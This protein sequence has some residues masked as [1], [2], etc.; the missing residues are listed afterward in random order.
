L[1]H[2]FKAL[3]DPTRRSILE[4]L[5][6]KDMSAGEIAAQF[7]MSWPSVSHHLELLRKAGLVVAEKEGQYVYYSINTTVMDDMLKWML[8]FT[9][10]RK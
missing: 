3:N 5:R 2:L 4:M 1:N 6:D 10:K 7:D 9:K 8:Q